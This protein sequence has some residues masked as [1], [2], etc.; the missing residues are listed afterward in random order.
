[1]ERTKELRAFLDASHSVYHTAKNLADMLEKEGYTRL[2]ESEKWELSQGGKYYLIRGGT[3]VLAFRI[4]AAEPTGFM[5]T[6]SHADRPTFKV[7]ENG[8]L[9]GKYTRLA[10]EK[11]GGM[12]MA[13]WLDR[14]LSVAGRVMVRT[15]KGVE[16]R[17]LDIDRD[18]LL[19][20]NVV[21]VIIKQSNGV[22]KF[23]PMYSNPTPWLKTIVPV[24]NLVTF[25]LLW[26][27][28]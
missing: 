27:V 10:T 7:K 4:P 9:D 23:V 5:M 18:L 14:P 22:A 11:Y 17:L 13:P 25:K 3:A 12:L 26:M 1:M 28:I 2:Y 15:E 21:L 20:P 6:A 24:A 8:E 19:I 16:A